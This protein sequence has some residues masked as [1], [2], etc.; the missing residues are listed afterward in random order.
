VKAKVMLFVTRNFVVDRS[1]GALELL[2]QDGITGPRAWARLFW[3]AF[4]RP[5]MMRKILAAWASFFL[6]GF[7]PWNQDDRALIQAADPAYAR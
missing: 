6:P 3:F 1:A 5:G 2:R 4:V 7:H